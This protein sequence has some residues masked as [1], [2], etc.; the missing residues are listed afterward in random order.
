M[1][2]NINVIIRS[3]LLNSIDQWGNNCANPSGVMIVLIV[4]MLKL[5]GGRGAGLTRAAI[6]R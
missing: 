2:D 5:R 4:S 1:E 6:R 3:S